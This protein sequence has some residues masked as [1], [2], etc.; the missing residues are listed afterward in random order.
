MGVGVD[1]SC[2]AVVLGG[3]AFERRRIHQVVVDPDVVHE[4]Q[5]RLEMLRWLMCGDQ[6]VSTAYEWVRR[7]T[8]GPV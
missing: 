7:W 3:A 6:S 2:H 1:C 8:K 4:G 5:V